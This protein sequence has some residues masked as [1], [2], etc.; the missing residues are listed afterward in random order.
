MKS[1]Q[2]PPRSTNGYIH[3]LAIAIVTGFRAAY[4]LRREPVFVR[5]A[6]VGGRA[7]KF[8]LAGFF[9]PVNRPIFFCLASAAVLITS[10]VEGAPVPVVRQMDLSAQEETLFDSARHRAVPVV[11][12]GAASK[13]HP[14]PLAILSHGY[15]GRAGAYTFIAKDLVRRGFMVVSIEHLE[16]PGDPEMVNGENLALRRRP[17]WQI[18][19]D[20]IAF[21]MDEMTRRG[22]T[23]PTSNALVLGHSNGGD[24]TM[25]FATDHPDRVQTALS[26]DNRRMPLP[27][28]ARPRVCSLRS[29]DQPADPGVLPTPEEQAAHDMTILSV[30]V[31]H[32]DM[33]DGADTAQK[34]AMLNAIAACLDR[35]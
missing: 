4:R 32:N 22:V 26:L 30:P 16:L 5:M 9:K 14:K 17:V 13:N 15:G 24:M 18:G 28:T 20:S 1:R 6:P 19:S 10:C 25:L 2:C 34:Q 3:R 31:K 8:R 12:Y 35:R 27:R 29:T 21:V 11:I 23:M 33:W 7:D